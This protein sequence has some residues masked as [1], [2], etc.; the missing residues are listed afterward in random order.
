MSKSSE[1]KKKKS[2]AR[3]FDTLYVK[4]GRRYVPHMMLMPGDYLNEGIWVVTKTK[5]IKGMSDEEYLRNQFRSV[6]I[7]DLKHFSAAEL[8]G[9]KELTDKLAMRFNEVLEGNASIYERCARVIGI[10][11][12]ES[13]K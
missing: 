13:E 4:K 11:F 6:R 7:S 5:Y 8:G 12:D 9:A 10:L 2:S 3:D 1:S